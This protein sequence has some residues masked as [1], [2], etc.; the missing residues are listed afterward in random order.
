MPRN[1]LF[2]TAP[3]VL[4][5]VI[6]GLFAIRSRGDNGANV[7]TS[8]PKDCPPVAR[9]DAVATK[10][11]T[12]IS[13]DVLANDTDPDGDPLVFQILRTTGGDSTIDDGG[14][15]TDA[16]DDR[17]LFTPADPAP[18]S[19]TIEYQALDPQGAVGESTVSVS[20]NADGVLPPGVESDPVPANAKSGAGHCSGGTTTTASTDDTVTGETTTPDTTDVTIED[21]G[22]STSNS[23]S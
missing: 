17:V 3:I 15:P 11:G 9:A 20:I 18:D 1:R 7:D 12:P 22:G 8:Q 14:T 16:S 23:K 2:F 10:P 4:A 21:L 13:I 5:V 19:A 6:I